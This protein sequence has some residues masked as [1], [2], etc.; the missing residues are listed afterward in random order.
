MEY[1][2]DVLL[3]GDGPTGLA[4]ALDLVRFGLS[5]R[6][7]DAKSG[8]SRL[9]KALILH[10]RTMEVFET[11]GVAKAIDSE[12]LPFVALNVRPLP[13]VPRIRLDQAASFW[14]DVR[15]S[16]W[17]CL[18][19]EHTERLLIKALLEQ[20]QS[21]TWNIRLVSVSNC[22]NCVKARLKTPTG[23]TKIRARWLLGCDGGRGATRSLVGIQRKLTNLR[24]S[25][26][27]ADV[28]A[29]TGLPQDEGHA[30]PARAGAVLIVP[31]LQHGSFR[32]I[33]SVPGDTGEPQDPGWYDDLIRRR[34]GLDFSVKAVS[35][36]SL[37][38]V[39]GGTVERLRSGNLF[40]LGDAAHIHSRWEDIG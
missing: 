31:M 34:A 8:L 9:S 17:R 39:R 37:F 5:V 16:G 33:L 19:Q 14:G 36:V 1:D 22:S 21:V 40:L 4:A 12:S 2:W 30:I 25:F 29:K 20:G 23:S 6:L 38:S 10:R 27:V 35:W 18:P 3:V 13:F 11:L 24:T 7:I 28:S 26:L 15:F 32:L